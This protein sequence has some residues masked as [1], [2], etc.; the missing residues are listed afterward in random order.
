MTPS[1]S[2]SF[3]YKTISG[4]S[5]TIPLLVGGAIFI[6]GANG[7]GK[8]GLVTHISSLNPG[9]T[10]RIS[11]HR[12]T[13]FTSNTLDLTPTGK[14]QIE[15]RIT[16]ADV[17]TESRWK[18]DYH[19]QRSQITI[20]NL[21]NAENLL[22]RLALKAVRTNFDE[23]QK[24][25]AQ[26]TPLETLNQLLQLSTLPIAISI[27]DDEK[28]FAT[29]NGGDAYSIAQLSDGER[30]AILI[31][32]DVLTAK[33]GTL[34][35]IDEPERHLHRSIISPLLSSLFQHRPDCAFVIAT[36]DIGL[37]LDNPGSS[38]LVVRQCAWNGNNISGWDADLIPATDDIDEE[39]RQNI[40]G[41]RRTI[42]FVEGTESS[43]DH[44]IYRILFPDISVIPQGNCTAVEQAVKGILATT[45]INWVKAFGLIDADDRQPDHLKELQ[46]HN[47]YALPCY[48]VESIYYSGTMIKNIALN[49]TKLHGGDAKELEAK[50][51]K[52][53]IDNIESH[54]DRLCARVCERKVKNEITF[55][56]WKEIQSD[57]VFNHQVNLESYFEA[58]KKQFDTFIS[59][60]D[61]DSIVGRYPVRETEV[62]NELAKALKFQ[63]RVDYENAVRKLLIDDESIRLQ[64]RDVL[65]DL[66]AAVLS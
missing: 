51:H 64:T 7:T 56:S 12:Q 48:S 15:S 18:D 16:N 10:K 29:K 66:A 14:A 1:S 50:A 20:Y 26:K 5:K 62:L 43:L 9:T 38:V 53:I 8:S 6:L 57:K 22:A 52:A 17:Q 39:V 2:F 4:E 27:A 32:T 58:E 30:N 3:S 49:V 21:I 63:K 31:A 55:P 44:H 45:S 42:L 59:S 41:A 37:P 65:G 47:I 23:A 60:N 36:H 13:W 46:D 54:K 61:I 34:F 40:V 19:Q 33:A 25:G 11:A 28:V 24:I 35:I